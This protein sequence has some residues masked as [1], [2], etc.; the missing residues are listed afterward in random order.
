[1]ESGS[2]NYLPPSRR[3]LRS[4]VSNLRTHLTRE[5]MNY[6]SILDN[7][8]RVLKLARRTG[9]CDAFVRVKV[10]AR[11]VNQK[12][13]A[14]GEGLCEMLERWSRGRVL[15][16]LVG[17]CPRFAE[18]PRSRPRRRRHFRS[19]PGASRYLRAPR[20][21]GC[22]AWAMLFFRRHHGPAVG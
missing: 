19:R 16:P 8:A 1:M 12:F 6:A 11:S 13:A 22:A 7:P 2:A 5:R 4:Y 17:C 9:A 18:C 14:A 15:G 10:L 3:S 20:P 21:G